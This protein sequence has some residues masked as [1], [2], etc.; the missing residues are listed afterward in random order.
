MKTFSELTGKEK[1]IEV[2]RWIAVL[3]AAALGGA[4]AH[5]L[6]ILGNSPGCTRGMINPDESIIDR[7][8]VVTISN[9]AFGATVVIAGA[10]TAPR[11]RR[12]TAFVLTGLLIFTSGMLVTVLIGKPTAFADYLAVVVATASAIGGA[13]YIHVQESQTDPKE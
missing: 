6:I 11:A 7:L 1:L 4:A 9:I 5:I 3:P 13:I 2:L 10:K 8:M 12:V